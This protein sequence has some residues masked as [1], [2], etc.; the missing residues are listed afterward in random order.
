MRREIYKNIIM[1]SDMH[2]FEFV[3]VGK[4]GHIPK[5]VLFI[6][7][8]DPGVYN[9]EFGDIKTDGNIDYLVVSDNGDMIKVLATVMQIIEIYTEKYP[10]RAIDFTGS[11]RERMRLY[12]MTIGLHLEELSILFDIYTKKNNA[13]APFIKNTNASGF[14]FKRKKS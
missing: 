13:L 12:R 10:E 9:L 1:A 6:P 8:D 11:S 4:K 5:Q 3:S 14:L 7:A 2:A